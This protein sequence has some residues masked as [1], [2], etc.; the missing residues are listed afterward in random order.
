MHKNGFTLME[1]LAVV[2]I[3][4]ILT[5]V[6]LPQYR[7]SMERSRVAE[8]L[9]MLPAIFDARERLVTERGFSWA[10]V[11]GHTLPSWAGEVSF[12]KLDI[13]MKGSATSTSQWNTDSFTYHL[14]PAQDSRD[15]SA[16]L[17][18]GI[19]KNAVITYDGNSFSC[20]HTDTA[21]CTA[22]NL[23]LSVSCTGV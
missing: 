15:V 11:N 12:S 21:V 5:A 22:L 4:G 23:A 1:L 13:E 20:C 10:G 6:A 17:K 9:Q 2:L 3:L 16:T 8:A 14:F 18:K 7:K 19:Y